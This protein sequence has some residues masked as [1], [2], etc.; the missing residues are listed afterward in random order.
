MEKKLLYGQLASVVLLTCLAICLTPLHFALAVL[1]IVIASAFILADEFWLV[2]KAGTV[3]K[4]AVV[5]CVLVL[6]MTFLL[7]LRCMI[8]VLS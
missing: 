3:A 1:C 4:S 5:A 2:E 8:E 7:L 6:N